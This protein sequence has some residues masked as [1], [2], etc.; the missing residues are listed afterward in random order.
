MFF[1]MLVETIDEN[2]YPRRVYVNVEP[3]SKKCYEKINLM[4]NNW[5]DYN[6]IE[7]ALIHSPM[8][9][10]QNMVQSDYDNKNRPDCMPLKSS[11]PNYNIR[12]EN[13]QSE[14]RHRQVE[15]PMGYYEQLM[16]HDWHCKVR[17]KVRQRGWGR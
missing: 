17:G 11:D 10:A 2:E 8:K 5:S 3:Y 9:G 13:V 7:S 15:L 12:S 16:R 1:F 14:Y 4:H 6:Q